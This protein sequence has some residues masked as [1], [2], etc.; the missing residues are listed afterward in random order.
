MIVFTKYVAVDLHRF[1][2][3]KHAFWSDDHWTNEEK[4]ATLYESA[5]FAYKTAED[6]EALRPH[7]IKVQF[8][9]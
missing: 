7:C 6:N 3:N 5:E 9:G 8:Q 1:E 4:K 2:N